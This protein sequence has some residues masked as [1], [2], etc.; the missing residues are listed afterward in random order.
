MKLTIAQIMADLKVTPEVARIMKANDKFIAENNIKSWDEY[1]A[2]VRAQ[3]LANHRNFYR[4]IIATGLKIDEQ[5]AEQIRKF[6]N[7]W[8]DHFRW[9]ETSHEE[10]I[11]EAKIVQAMMANPKYADMVEVVEKEMK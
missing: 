2:T 10:I 7:C 3:R 6:I 1:H 11:R 5:S 4:E 9:S 8:S